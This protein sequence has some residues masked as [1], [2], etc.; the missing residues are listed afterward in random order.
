MHSHQHKIHDEMGAVSIDCWDCMWTRPISPFPASDTPEELART[1]CEVVGG[2]LEDNPDY[3]SS[4]LHRADVGRNVAAATDSVSPYSTRCEHCVT[5]LMGQHELGECCGDP[6]ARGHAL[7]IDL[8]RKVRNLRLP[9]FIEHFFNRL[10]VPPNS[11]REIEIA[12]LNRALS[13]CAKV[14]CDRRRW[15]RN[16]VP[17]NAKKCNLETAT[18]TRTEAPWT[19]SL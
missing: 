15:W 5:R 8:A 12:G 14:N 6:A 2:R 4:H 7:L 13:L 9:D 3:A 18:T 11:T 10:L 19:R 17:E 1:Q 16:T